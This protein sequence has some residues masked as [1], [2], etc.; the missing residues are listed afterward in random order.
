[1]SFVKHFKFD[2]KKPKQQ[3]ISWSPVSGGEKLKGY[4]EVKDLFLFFSIVQYLY[5]MKSSNSSSVIKWMA[6]L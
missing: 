4:N 5:H 6:L 2:F 3:N 1:M